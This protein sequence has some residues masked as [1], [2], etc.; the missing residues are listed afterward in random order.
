MSVRAC[1][2]GEAPDASWN[3]VLIAHKNALARASK[4][5]M[6]AFELLGP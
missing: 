5:S 4:A 2:R 6:G 3:G 1:E